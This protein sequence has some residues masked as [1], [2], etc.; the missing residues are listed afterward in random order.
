M[1]ITAPVLLIAFNRPETTQQ[2]FDS[3]KKARPKRFYF[4]VDGPRPGN[5][6]DGINCRKTRDIIKQVD[7]DCEVFTN[8][9]DQNRGCA[10]G[11]SGAITWAFSNEDRMII[12]EDDTVAALPFF[13]YCEYLLEKFKHDTRICMISG[14]N[15]TEEDNN[16]DESYYFSYFGHIW[17]WATWK[18]AW[19]TFDLSMSDWPLFRD[20]GQIKNLFTKRKEQQYFIS[21]YTD[22]L[23]EKAKGTWDY[24]WF[25]CRF[26][27]SG[28]SIVPKT[29]LVTNVGV[30]G[31][32]TK[33][34]ATAH[35]LPVSENFKIE[36]EPQFIIRNLHYD[37][38][39]FKKIIRLKRSIIARAFQ[40]LIKILSINSK[41]SD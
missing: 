3:I 33:I 25:Y 13:S 26:K 27:N 8:F 37:T 22:F 39:H 1:P 7:W 2:V 14:N 5:E 17:G 18:R 20:T 29:N 28:L 24:Q 38:Y 36:K 40:K 30:Q 9:A 19:D 10:K 4:S 35:F 16:T 34:K 11:V 41:K 12:L 32:H 31:T 6:T 23:Q 15:Y 21:F